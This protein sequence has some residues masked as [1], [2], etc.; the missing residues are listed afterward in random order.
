MIPVDPER[1]IADLEALAEFG[2]CGTGVNRRALTPEDC[3][4]RAWLLERMQEA[5]LEARIDGI[6]SVIGKTPGASRYIIIASHSDTVPQGG[7]LDGAMGVVYG[8]EIARALVESGRRSDIGVKVISFSDEEGRFVGILGS[9]V[10]AGL[11]R[12]EDLAGLRADD[13]TG[14]LEALEAAGYAGQPVGAFTPGEDIAY[15]EAH[16]EQGPVLEARGC[17]IGAVTEIVGVER[18]VVDFHGQADHAGTTPMAMR[19]DAAAALYELA[20]RFAEHCR[21]AGS[22]STVWNLGKATL[23]PGAYNVVAREAS[24][25]FEYRDASAAVLQRIRERLP[26]LAATAARRY[27]CEHE[28]LP[29]IATTPAVMD[30]ALVSRIE[31][32]ARE[33]EASCMRMPSGAGH[34]AMLFA[35]RI[36]TAMLFIPSI[37]GRSHDVAED[38]DRG[39]IALGL[40]VSSTFID[41]LIRE[42]L[43]G[44][45]EGP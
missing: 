32:A 33:R 18:A 34:D 21:S 42:G 24:L 12:F 43:P 20:V 40:E 4:S 27:N 31:A 17:R 10:Y 1:C 22:E 2:R 23:A 44:G 26:E 14:F 28:V 15:L 5:G 11:K 37:G 41:G 3:A 9:S 36:P 19:K 30:A 6:G 39:D 25:H 7:W 13:G 38:S 45:R 35:E 29:G 8:L 16:I